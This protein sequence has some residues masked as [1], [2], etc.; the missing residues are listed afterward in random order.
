MKSTESDVCYFEVDAVLNGEQTITRN[1]TVKIISHQEGKTTKYA[2]HKC[3]CYL[4]N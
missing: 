3:Y 2:A 4:H 1:D